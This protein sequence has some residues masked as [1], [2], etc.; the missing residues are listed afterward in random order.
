VTAACAAWFRTRRRYLLSFAERRRLNSTF[1][2]AYTEGSGIQINPNGEQLRP[3]ETNSSSIPGAAGYLIRQPPLS[4]ARIIVGQ[5]MCRAG[6][7]TST[8]SVAQLQSHVRVMR[9]IKDVSGFHAMFGHD[10]E[11]PADA[12]IACWR[13]AR[14]K[15]PQGKLALGNRCSIHLSYG[16]RVFDFTTLRTMSGPRGPESYGPHPPLT[17][18]RILFADAISQL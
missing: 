6:V 8:K 2:A 13:A 4:F 14:D 10:P 16:A 9:D 7:P 3:E 17:E 18:V 15:W 11:L 12:S 5:Q 1:A